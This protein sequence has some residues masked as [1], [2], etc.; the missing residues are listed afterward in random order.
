[1]VALKEVAM[2]RRPVNRCWLWAFLT[3][4]L[5]VAACGVSRSQQAIVGNWKFLD[6]G[7][8]SADGR[9]VAA[10]YSTDCHC[11]PLLNL[12]LHFN[13]DKTVKRIGSGPSLTGT[14]TFVDDNH[15]RIDLPAEPGG[16]P[17]ST[18][19]EVIISANRLILRLSADDQIVDQRFNRVP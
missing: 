10:E 11:S 18:V 8:T 5:A 1:M 15:M 7:I 4:L 14:Y 3:V 9:F 13:Q 6:S 12:E 2:F 17:S 16:T 19:Y